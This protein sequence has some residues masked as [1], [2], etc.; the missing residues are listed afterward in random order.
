MAVWS[1]A[2]PVTASFE[3]RPWQMRELPLALGFVV[4]FAGFSGFLHQL[5]KASHDIAAIWQKNDEKNQNFRL[6]TIQF[7]TVLVLNE[8]VDMVEG[9]LLALSDTCLPSTVLIIVPLAIF[10]MCCV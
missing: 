3:N 6:L 10:V 5:Q 4:F 1:E 2:L 9:I 7:R 8:V